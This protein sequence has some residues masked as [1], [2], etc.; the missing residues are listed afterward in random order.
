MKI[1]TT[2]TRLFV[3]PIYF[4]LSS[5]Y[6]QA[7]APL[8]GCTSTPKLPLRMTESA[9]GEKKPLGGGGGGGGGNVDN[10]SRAREVKSSQAVVSEFDRD[11]W[12]KQVR[13][14]AMSSGLPSSIHCC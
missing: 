10:A 12:K 3:F 2:T 13:F 6:Q 9:A 11:E 5:R 7:Q 8:Q 1:P 4:L 14:K